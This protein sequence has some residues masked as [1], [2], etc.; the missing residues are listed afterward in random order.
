[1]RIL[2]TSVIAFVILA[3]LAFADTGGTAI[4]HGSEADSHQQEESITGQLGIHWDQLITHIIAFIIAVWI[5]KRFAWKPI[6]GLLEERRQKIKDEFDAIDDKKVELE[7]LKDEYEEKLKEIDAE[8][9]QRIN[10]AVNEGQ[11][12]A[13]EIKEQAKADQKKEIEKAKQKIEAEIA[14]ARTQLRDDMV[15]MAIQAASKAISESMDEDK[16]R[17]LISNFIDD[18]EKVK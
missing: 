16:H 10:E 14:A 4:S 17:K 18:L 3:G 13:A 7:N 15:N 5:L 2:I 9:R 1:M 8:A 12:I 11:K 6:L